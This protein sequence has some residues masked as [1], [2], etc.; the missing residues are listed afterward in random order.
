MTTIDQTT[1]T[2]LTAPGLSSI[3]DNSINE[4]DSLYEELSTNMTKLANKPELVH[5]PKVPLVSR[6]LHAAFS[7]SLLGLLGIFY[8]QVGQHIHDNHILVPELASKPLNIAFNILNTLSFGSAP[9]PLLYAIQGVFLG[10]L[11]PFSDK[12]LFR[13][14]ASTSGNSAS[15]DNTSIVR[16]GI[17]FLGVAFAVRKIEWA[18]SIQAAV[19]WTLL[20]PCLW[21]LLDGTLAGITTGFLVA[22]LASSSVIVA[23]GLPHLF[24]QDLEFI[25]TMLWLGN[26]YFF[27]VIIF[28]KI[29]RYLFEQ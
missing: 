7:V 23:E 28:G 24:Y 27:G 18:S 20:S 15:L 17:A 2:E 19:A 12:F 29:G 4:N 26:F 8:K 5:K 3:Y 10:C 21:L 22:L 13:Y 16:S 25:A 11:L 9:R 1:D 14:T 6:I